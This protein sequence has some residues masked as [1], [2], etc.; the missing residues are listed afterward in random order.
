MDDYDSADLFADTP[1]FSDDQVA[2]TGLTGDAGAVEPLPTP[3]QVIVN[4]F[5]GASDEAILGMGDAVVAGTTEI[6][7]ESPLVGY[8]DILR[9]SAAGTLV[10]PEPPAPAT[11]A[12]TEFDSFSPDEIQVFSEAI[13][14]RER[15]PLSAP[16]HLRVA[17]DRHLGLISAQEAF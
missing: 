12:V 13:S 10:A 8:M 17:V 11:A 3:E 6:E 5:E 9:Q 14:M 16:E 1:A 2:D 4:R 7:D 15:L